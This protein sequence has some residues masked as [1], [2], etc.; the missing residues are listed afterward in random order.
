MSNARTKRYKAPE[1]LHRALRA[2]LPPENMRVS[3][4]AERY[5]ELSQNTTNLA[6]PWRNEV[7]P[8]LVG[9][10][11][12]FNNPETERI[13]FCKPTQ[14]GGTQIIINAVGWAVMQ[15]PGPMLIAE[16][17]EALQN[18]LSEFELQPAI[19]ACPELSEYFLD[20]DSEKS[21]LKFTNCHVTIA[22]S[23]SVSDAAMRAVMILCLDEVDKYPAKNKNEGDQVSLFLERTS[24]FRGKRKIYITSTPT[25]RTGRIWREMEAADVIRHY[26]VPCPHCG[27]F[28]EFKLSNIRWPGKNDG[29]DPGKELSYSD[30]AEQAVYICPA[31]GCGG[32]IEDWMKQ[33]MLIKGEWRD[34]H[35]NAKRA[36]SVAFWINALYSPFKTFPE[37]ALKHMQTHKDPGEHQNFTN[38]WLAEPWEELRM[39]TSA[40]SVLDRQTN[41]S[42][43]TV[44]GW[45]RLLTAGVDVQESHLYYTIRAWGE[46]MTSQCIDHGMVTTLDEISEI[47]NLEYRREDGEIYQV[48]L[49][50]ID[51]GFATD[52]IYQF[53]YYN[54]D[55]AAPVLGDR[56]VQSQYYR[57]ST[58]EKENSIANGMTM[59]LANGGMLK[60]MI[61]GRL[62]KEI[63]DNNGEGSGSWMVYKGCDQ[64]YAQ[65]ITAEQE[66]VERKGGAEVK[67]W[68]K[69]TSHAANHYL[70]CEVYA[71]AAAEV[72]RV[73]TMHLRPQGQREEPSV[74]AQDIPMQNWIHGG[75]PAEKLENWVQG[76]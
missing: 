69:K 71:A 74:T 60:S 56:H 20:R 5:R 34:V 73:R 70:D 13:I 47:M 43:Y 72:R 42:Q 75:L 35:R 15:N 22:T 19:R 10:M 3:Q 64:E 28:I 49:T 24:T 36:R 76:G 46:H 6:G 4:W 7:T 27:T 59:V 2:L 50:L 8:Y 25:L 16:P 39:R 48:S 67:K 21:E 32:V 12:E 38:S 40:D 26:F 57:Y 41:I 17:T 53:C 33:D 45:G 52:E 29:P 58:I 18:Y 54:S 44:P 23:N 9:P 37:I 65:Q 63:G 14:V 55:W 11:D 31:E 61:H 66:V 30:R 1:Y 68:V 62:R 51:A